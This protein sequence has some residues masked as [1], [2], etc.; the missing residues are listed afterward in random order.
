ML[1]DLLCFNFYLNL[2][3]LLFNN[4]FR[5]CFNNKMS[6]VTP[7]LIVF[8]VNIA[9]H[10]GFVVDDVEGLFCF[11]YNFVRIEDDPFVEFGFRWAQ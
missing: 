4:I 9:G 1:D 6:T 10:E 11:L 2:G 5:Y 8:S 7:K 3:C